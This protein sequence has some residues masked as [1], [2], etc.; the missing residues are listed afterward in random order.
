MKNKE[1]SVADYDLVVRGGMVVTAGGNMRCDLGVR[2]ER[3]VALGEG[4]TA[5]KREINAR[6]KLVL[7]GGVDSHCH[8]EEPW[9]G[10]PRNADSFVS[11]TTAAAFGGTTTVIPFVVQQKGQRLE[12]E[13]KRYHEI[14]R[15]S[16]IDYSF[17]L[18]VS[19]PNPVVLEELPSLIA[20]GHRSIK[21]FLTYDPVFLND[22]QYLDVLAVARE[23]GALVTVH[24]EN[25][26]AIKWMTERLLSAGLTKP[27]HH[28]WAKPMLVEREA[29]HRAIALAELLDVPLQIFHV[30]GAEVIDEIAR[31]QERGIK[32][33][34]ETCPQYL[35]LTD[36]DLDRSDF[37]GAKF[38]CSPAPRTS[39]DQDALWEA[40]ARGTLDVV[41]SDHA[42]F[43]FDD[44]EGKKINGPNAS[45]DQVPN[46]VP[47][48]E[49]RMPL[50]FSEGVSKGRIGLETFVALSSTNPAKLFGLYPRKGTLQIGADADIVIWDQSRRVTL[51]NEMLHHNVD[52]TPYE[53]HEIIGWPE[54]TIARGE[55]VSDGGKLVAKPGRGRFLAR[56]PYDYISPTGRLPTPFDPVRGEVISSPC[57]DQKHGRSGSRT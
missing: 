53:G 28:A 45:F 56:E 54:T 31:A 22:L 10:G 35:L 27:L 37:E 26:S 36:G 46:G 32:V 38:I 41:S 42:P 50:L 44:P 4:L 11:A 1:S 48:I 7:P 33:F 34:G 21:V 9:T 2:D 47:G 51:R 8:I 29:T 12:A 16:L 40:L 57:P 20:E 49:T 3:I 5:G 6:D 14:A 17:H 23:C 39:A 43:R 55:I 18:I 13:V 19:D 15:Q 24:A 52:Y 30:S 25:H